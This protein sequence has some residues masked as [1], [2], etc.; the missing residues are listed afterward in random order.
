MYS[1]LQPVISEKPAALSAL[2]AHAPRAAARH[3]GA[4]SKAS[5]RAEALQQWRRGTS[6]LHLSCAN[7]FAHGVPCLSGSELSSQKCAARL[8]KSRCRPSPRTSP[9][10]AGPRSKAGGSGGSRASLD[11]RTKQEHKSTRI[12]GS[13]ST[14]YLIKGCVE[15]AK[16]ADSQTIR[17]VPCLFLR[18]H[19]CP[20]PSSIRRWMRRGAYI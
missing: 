15:P 4:K 6:V 5:D 12:T 1:P 2:R 7:F 10:A 8:Y 16:P 3:P 9:G 13:N 18:H 20:A 14:G 17:E 11:L 19:T